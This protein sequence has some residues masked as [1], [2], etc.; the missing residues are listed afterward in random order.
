[1]P[2]AELAG[3]VAGRPEHEVGAPPPSALQAAVLG[4]ERL[5]P[6]CINCGARSGGATDGLKGRCVGEGHESARSAERCFHTVMASRI[7]HSGRLATADELRWRAM[8]DRL[9][10]LE[11][12]VVANDVM[13]KAIY[14]AYP[15]SGQLLDEIESLLMTWELRETVAA[16]SKVAKDSRNRLRMTIAELRQ[17]ASVAARES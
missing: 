6:F 12:W 13:M 7:P 15:G 16:Q 17:S 5:V 10:T 14:A 11:S 1:M 2:G 4:V 8:A 9:Q 3:A